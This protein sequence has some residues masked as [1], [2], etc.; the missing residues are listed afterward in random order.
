MPGIIAFPTIVEEAVDE[1][2]CG[3]VWS[4]DFQRFVPFPGYCG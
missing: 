3:Q 1:F 4:L 2:G